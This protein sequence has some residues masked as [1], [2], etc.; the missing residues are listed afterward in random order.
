MHNQLESEIGRRTFAILEVKVPHDKSVKAIY[1]WKD[2]VR[3]LHTL[4]QKYDMAEYCFVHSF[5]HEALIEME[6]INN[7]YILGLQATVRDSA[8]ISSKLNQNPR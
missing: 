5:D 7:E 6:R 3:H 1:R 2:C 8:S 4:I